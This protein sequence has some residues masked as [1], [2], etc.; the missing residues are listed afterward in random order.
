MCTYSDE[1]AS[2]A[3]LDYLRSQP[4]LCIVHLHTSLYNV[5]CN[6][7]FVKCVVMCYL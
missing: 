7:L 6:V 5:L 2:F 1:H 3:K 4:A